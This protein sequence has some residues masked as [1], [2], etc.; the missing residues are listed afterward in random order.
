MN[1]DE[2]KKI[3]DALARSNAEME[4]YSQNLNTQMDIHE[5][6]ASLIDKSNSSISSYF[7]TS[8]DIN[9]LE[10]KNLQLANERKK[11]EEE[12]KTLKEAQDLI[13]KNITGKNT[14]KEKALIAQ[15]D[16][17]VKNLT[18]LQQ[19]SIQLEQN[20][21]AN[22]E[23]VRGFKEQASLLGTIGQSIQDNLVN[24][25]TKINHSIN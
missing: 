24:R 7:K 1:K 15:R 10:K 18:A 3:A 2:I 8:K 22:N 14:K 9:N 20:I 13:E 21:D 25:F 6:I 16:L 19:Q 5:K 4:K 11:L 17:L 23:I 12:L